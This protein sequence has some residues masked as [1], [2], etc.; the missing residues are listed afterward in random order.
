LFNT[1]DGN[2]PY[3][4]FQRIAEGSRFKVLT[5]ILKIDQNP[6]NQDNKKLFFIKDLDY[7]NPLRY[8][9]NIN[10]VVTFRREI[11]NCNILIALI[12]LNSFEQYEFY[13]NIGE[14][15]VT[16]VDPDNN[17][18]DVVLDKEILITVNRNFNDA[19][20]IDS[21]VWLETAEQSLTTDTTQYTTDNTTLTTDMTK[22]EE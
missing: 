11:P 13:S 15:I 8:M 12:K 18:I 16:D 7:D 21:K 3:I 10:G 1:L 6:D 17:E 2:K 4:K 5:N 22:I 20:L 14:F 19:D 9:Y